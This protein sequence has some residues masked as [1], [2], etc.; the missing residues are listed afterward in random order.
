[1]RARRG[2]WRPACEAV[3]EDLVVILF[4]Q[5]GICAAKARPPEEP[6]CKGACSSRAPLLC[7]V[8]LKKE[9]WRLATRN[10]T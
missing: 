5:G 9:G 3:A 6:G 1:M 4:W 2:S 10:Q 8:V 7:V